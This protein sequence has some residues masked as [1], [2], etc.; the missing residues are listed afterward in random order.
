MPLMVA[1]ICKFLCTSYKYIDNL[2]VI[3]IVVIS[4]TK[5]LYYES[6]F[7]FYIIGIYSN[8]YTLLLF[9]CCFIRFGGGGGAKGDY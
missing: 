7:T 6:V 3:I 1:W 9:I 8:I 4:T 5:H 2:I